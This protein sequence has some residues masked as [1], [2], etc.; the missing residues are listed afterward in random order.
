MVSIDP[1]EALAL[2]GVE[3]W[4]DQYDLAKREKGPVAEWKEKAS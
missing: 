4:Y 3:G 2:E 1:S